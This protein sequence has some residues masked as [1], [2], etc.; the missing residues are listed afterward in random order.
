MKKFVI[1]SLF[2]TLSMVAYANP[3]PAMRGEQAFI[4]LPLST[5]IAQTPIA[6]LPTPKSA[7]AQVVKL[8]TVLI[9]QNT[10]AGT[11]MIDV[12]LID[13]FIEDV[14]PNA[15][16]YPPNFPNRT[17]QHL[18]RE[19]IKYL[20][21][22]LEPFARDPN[23]SFDLLIRATKINGMGRNL[24]LGS[25]YGVRASTHIANALK[26]RPNDPE[27]NFLYGMMLS[28]GGGF[29]EGK[30]YLDKASQLG[31]LE[32]EQSL[33]QADL[34]SDKRHLAIQRLQSLVLA[35]P[36]NTQLKTQLEIVQN[37]GYYIWDIKDN[38]L[39]IKPINR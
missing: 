16:H 39:N 9:P 7:V 17:A 36:N 31:Y 38:N 27:A 35:H 15:R 21:E 11:G 19:N 26:Q 6:G 4:E 23:A 14:S 8:P 24:D 30:K 25:D 2:A 10:T 34:L 12:T 29:K 3:A 18:T 13:D 22:W 20:A 37:G 1:T 32:A 28:E 33:A 5:N